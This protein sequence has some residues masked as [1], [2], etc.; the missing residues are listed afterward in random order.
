MI[1]NWYCLLVQYPATSMEKPAAL[2]FHNNSNHQCLMQLIRLWLGVMSKRGWTFRPGFMCCRHTAACH[3]ASYQVISD[4]MV[5]SCQITPCYQGPNSTEATI[6]TQESSGTQVEG[7]VQ[8]TVDAASGSV[9][10]TLD[11]ID[12]L[13]SEKAPSHRWFDLKNYPL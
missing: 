9:A 4:H 12:A 13:S 2:P 8:A 3:I 6:L 7:T 1:C 10:H 11:L 5:I